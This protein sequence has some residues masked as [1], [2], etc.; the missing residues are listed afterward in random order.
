MWNLD[1]KVD[2]DKIG[3]LVLSSIQED[4]SNVNTTSIIRH[5]VNPETGS[6]SNSSVDLML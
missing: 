5:Y 2:I 4:T 6:Y 1:Q 3:N